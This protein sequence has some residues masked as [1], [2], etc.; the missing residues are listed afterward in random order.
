MKKAIFL[1]LIFIFPATVTAENLSGTSYQAKDTIFG[2]SGG[3]SGS[4][5]LYNLK[6]ILGVN[7][8]S[9]MSSDLYSMNSGFYNLNDLPMATI[10]NYNDGRSTEDQTPTLKW[11]YSDADN[12]TQK[13]YQLQIAREN[14]SSPVVDT[15]VLSSAAV[16][17]TS[18]ILPRT[19]ERTTY[20]WRV[21][22]N[23]GLDWSGW[24]VASNG[25][26]LTEG[27]FLISGLSALTS[28]GGA[29]IAESTWQKDNDPYF[30][31]E[32]PPI[33]VDILGYSF[34]LDGPPDDEIDTQET[35]YYFPQDDIGDG[36]HTFY[37]K[38]KRSSGLWSEAAE[39][40]IWVDT[41]APSVSSPAPTLGG[42][43]SDDQPQVQA[44]L[45]DAASGVNPDTIEMR[46]NQADV[47][48]EYDAESGKIT[49]TPSIPFSEG[50]IVVSLLIQDLV[51]NFSSPLTWSFIIDTQG[52]SGSILINSG[53]EMTTVNAVTLNISAQDATTAVVQMMLSNDGVFDIEAWEPYVSLRKN[54]V[55]PAINGI[56]RVYAKVKDEAGNISEVFFDEIQL[57]IVAPDTYILS[58]PSGITQ[59]QGAQF[60]FRGSLP[61]CQFSYKF[62]N[63]DWSDWSGNISIDKAGLAEGNH[64]FM[65]RSAK[66]LNKD[67]L[68]QLDEV[69][70]TPALRVW[71]ISLTGALKPPTEPEKPV[72]H[73]EEE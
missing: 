33:G 9:A 25:F 35:H 34:A 39:F 64:Y 61:D 17:Y 19:E 27:G 58:G 55:L 5:S 31:W 66:D 10:V 18:S 62:D 3:V 16:S 46:I 8:M 51:G 43:I 15:G 48:P 32:A 69:D 63:E 4:S 30:Y 12:D 20:Q 71:T 70:P 29:G 24:T 47:M 26:I 49:F 52:P 40:N 11:A 23:D 72:K 57:V 13:R 44:L 1:L 41:T 59:L 37:A 14:F 7:T 42:V 6:G 38:A 45:S 50:E 2:I 54:W 28:P 53:D 73:W 36:A 56:R 21:R 65:V 22:V 67:G 68:F 60:T